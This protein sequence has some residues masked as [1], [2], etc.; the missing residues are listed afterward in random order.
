MSESTQ[1]YEEARYNFGLIDSWYA[2]FGHKA[3]PSAQ[4]VYLKKQLDEYEAT[5]AACTPVRDEFH[6]SILTER[7]E[8]AKTLLYCMLKHQELLN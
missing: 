7:I 5:L 4:L 1:K 6:Y 8:R 2:L 3:T